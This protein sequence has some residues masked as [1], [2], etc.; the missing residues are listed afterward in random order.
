MV[1]N[2]SSAEIESPVD[3]V[4]SNFFDHK[5]LKPKY[6]VLLSETKMFDFPNKTKTLRNELSLLFWSFLAANVYG[7]RLTLPSSPILLLGLN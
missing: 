3:A 4:I 1:E 7:R 2:S 6:V 5:M